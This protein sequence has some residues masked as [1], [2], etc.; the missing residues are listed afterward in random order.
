MK[1]TLLTCMAVLALFA[2]AGSASAITC[3]ID[4]RPAATLLV[5]RFAVSLNHDGTV[6]RGPVVNPQSAEQN[7]TF[8]TLITIGNASAAPMIAH[9]SVFNERSYLVLDFNVALTGF[10]IQSWRMSDVISG[11]LPST[12]VDKNHDH[13]TDTNPGPSPEDACQRNP[14]SEVYSPIVPPNPAGFLR[15]KPATAALSATTDDPAFATT[16]YPIPAFLP[17]DTFGRNVIDSLDVDDPTGIIEYDSLGCTSETNG[18]TT[19]AAVGYITIDH[20]NYCNLSNPSDVNY[21]RF[22]AMGNENNL[23]GDIIFI[24]GE[25]IGTYGMSAV[26]IESDPSFAGNP[27]GALRTRTFYARY[28]DPLDTGITTCANCGNGI[29][30]Q[31]LLLSS[32]WNVGIGDQREPLGLKWGAR[33]F[34]RLGSVISNLQVWRASSGLLEDLTGIGCTEVE[35][36]V[37]LNFFDEDEN[38]VSQIGTGPCPSPCQTPPPS[39]FNFPLETN[40]A[41]VTNFTLPPAEAWFE[42]GLD[43]HGLQQPGRRHVARSGLRFVSVQRRRGVRLVSRAGRPARPVGLRAPGPPGRGQPGRFRRFRVVRLRRHRFA[44]VRSAFR[45]ARAHSSGFESGRDLASRP[46][47]LPGSLSFQPAGPISNTLEDQG[48]L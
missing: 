3:T 5:P 16:A 42:R 28:W 24:S 30:E 4:E 32:P 33:Y 2:I 36:T 39:T 27:Q 47:F 44:P 48:D 26:A 11:L 19:G 40:L 15:V 29:A 7:T 34:A 37:Q 45:W 8:D 23:Y 31:D 20:A 9:V 21:Y 18:I 41:L 12:P 14:L 46:L 1:K 35:P 17:S 25:G 43:Q 6:Y 22:N 13:P 38:G 10:D